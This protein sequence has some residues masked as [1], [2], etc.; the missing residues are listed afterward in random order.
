MSPQKEKTGI[1]EDQSKSDFQRS[2]DFADVYANNLRFEVSNW[3]LKLLFGQLEQSLGPQAVVQHT[4]VTIPWQQVKLT[5]YFLSIHVIVHE[6]Q[7]GRIKILPTLVPEVAKQLPKEL[8]DSGITEEHW[9][10]VRKLYEDFIAANPE[11][12]P[13]NK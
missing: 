3:D 10:T 13:K 12:A 1:E 8:K 4:G 6:A 11:A 5:S 7:A 9:K 2:E